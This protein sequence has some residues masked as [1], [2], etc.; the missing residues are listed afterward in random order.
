MQYQLL[1]FIS[2]PK[3]F[4]LFRKTKEENRQKAYLSHLQATKN[5]FNCAKTETS[6]KTKVCYIAYD[7]CI[8]N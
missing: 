4:E 2:E 3:E 5:Q 6:S 7:V 8:L 1:Q